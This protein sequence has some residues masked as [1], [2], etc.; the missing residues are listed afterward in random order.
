MAPG[1]FRRVKVRGITFVFKTDPDAPELL[2][3]Y[4]R[5]LKTPRDAINVW[6]SGEHAYHALFRRFEAYFEGVG[7]YWYPINLEQDVIMVVSCFDL[8]E[9]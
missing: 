7:L 4:A 2:H 1:Q 8:R 5:H 9:D 3:I 6:F